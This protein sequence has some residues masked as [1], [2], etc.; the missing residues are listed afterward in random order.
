MR[1]ETTVG[2]APPERAGESAAALPTPARR[3]FWRA[4][5]T[6]LLLVYGA[7]FVVWGTVLVGV[8]QWE[9]RRYLSTVT[10]QI[11]EQRARYFS[12]LDRARLPEAMQA[13]DAVYLQGV[14]AYGLFTAEGRYRFGNIARPPAGLPADGRVRELPE[15]I[16]R[17]D[18]PGDGRV[19]ARG[20]ALRLDSGE[21]MVLARDTGVIEHVGAILRQGLVWALS[22]TLIPGLVGGYL[23]GRGALQ[24][25]RRIEAAVQPIMRGR[26]DQ[27]LPV[28]GRRDELDLLAG[29][30]NAMLAELERRM[31]EVKSVCDNI[32][33]DLRTPLT[34]LR[35]QLHRLQQGPLSEDERSAL[36]AGCSA[37]VDALLGRFAAL[38]RISEM[39]DL[40][41]RAG[42]RS[43]ELPALLRE[44][45][46]LYAPLAEDKAVNLDLRCEPD[47]PPIAADRELLFEALSNLLD[48]AVKFT[49]AGGRVQLCAGRHGRG[50]E[51]GVLDSGPGIP[52]GER[53]AV[54]Q[55]F[56]RSARTCSLPG[57]GLGLSI[58]AAIARLHGFRLGIGEA[59]HGGARVTLYCPLRGLEA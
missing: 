26:L 7:L 16:A 17:R 37:D 49:P 9:T 1:A 6:R 3:I 40:R 36:L 31:G 30:V 52:A 13:A 48:N 45:Q 14:M 11:L 59:E 12:T 27:R 23:L 19:G 29:I 24:R 35:A 32:A 5:A 46:E 41:R 21:L 34:R 33:H 42:F 43:V 47:L 18:R 2:P 58:V 56:Y 22:L 25:V 50:I 39:E 20:L 28:S 15:G 44:L 55:R 10:D 57:S 4:S 53:E 51:F 38:L 54:L 8:V